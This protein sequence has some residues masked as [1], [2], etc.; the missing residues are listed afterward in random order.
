[1][2][3]QKNLIDDESDEVD[4]WSNEAKDDVKVDI[5]EDAGGQTHNF[6]SFPDS[7]MDHEEDTDDTSD[8][9]E[10]KKHAI[11]SFAFYQELFDVDSA[12]VLNRIKGSLIPS[13][14]SNFSRNYI[15]GKPDLY[16][17]FWISTTLIVT[18]LIC[19]NLTTL[20]SH[21]NDT[22][23]HYT[24]QFERLSIAAIIIYGYV[25]VIPLLFKGFLMIK[26]IESNF[27]YMD[28]MCT[29]GYSMFIFIPL[30]ML[31]LIPSP[32]V[33]WILVSIAAVVSGLVIIL[34]LNPIFETSDKVS[35]LAS[36]L[37]LFALHFSLALTF[38]L[39]FFSRVGLIA[40]PTSASNITNVINA[41]SHH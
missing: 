21:W 5:N 3:N 22:E 40:G 6:S 11:W 41:T 19:G 23:Y 26:K 9:L 2:S 38:R 1:M 20:L 14:N 15:G 16:G 24:P 13:R 28:I 30:S 4:L 33:D 29:Y 25:S 18:I 37:V 36:L 10:K 31:L 32:Y 39:Y 35:K 27:S 12:I 17:P 7:A 34:S 8:L